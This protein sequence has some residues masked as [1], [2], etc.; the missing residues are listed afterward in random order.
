MSERKCIKRLKEYQ[1]TAGFWLKICSQKI[2]QKNSM[3]KRI[4]NE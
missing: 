1:T 4:K 3:K 2:N